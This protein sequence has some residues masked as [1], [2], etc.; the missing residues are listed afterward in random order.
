MRTAALLFTPPLG[1]LRVDE[2]YTAGFGHA[3]ANQV[4]GPWAAAVRTVLDA[5]GAEV[6]LI[7]PP[8]DPAELEGLVEPLSTDRLDVV[9]GRRRRIPALDRPIN[10][11]ATLSLGSLALDV[12]SAVRAFRVPVLR[13]A[14]PSELSSD[15]VALLALS[16]NLYRFGEVP[17]TGAQTSS[18]ADRARRLAA[19]ARLAG[20][21]PQGDGDGHSTLKALEAA[22]PNFN[23]WLATTFA[24]WAGRRILEVG[25]GIGTITAHLAARADLVTALELEASYVERLRNRF[26]NRPN[27]EPL[28]SDVHLAD[29]RSLASRRFDTIVLSNVLEHLEDDAAAVRIFSRILPPKGRLIVYVP[30][31]PALFG[32]LDEAVGHH[33][34]YLPSTLRAVLDNNGFELVHMKWMNVVGIPAWLLNGRVL[35]KRALPPL[36]LRVYDVLAPTLARLEARLPLPVGMNLFA[37][38]SRRD[39]AADTHGPEPRVTAAPAPPGPASSSARRP[40]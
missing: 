40:A 7:D 3:G 27:V 39:D 29:W 10:A 36:Q 17:V 32:S 15:P 28:Q 5:T 1:P 31:L 37:V 4:P 20:Q 34:R 13:K 2:L 6:L 11:L 38:A 12:A 35:R 18:S 19:W 21:T 8:S 26:K 25:A 9:I 30:A 22:A 24:E 23:A 33:R 14:L 16:G